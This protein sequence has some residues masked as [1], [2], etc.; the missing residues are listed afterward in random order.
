MFEAILDYTQIAC[1]D[2]MTFKALRSKILRVGNDCI[3]TI[4]NNLSE[5]DI[6]YIPKTEEVIVIKNKKL[7]K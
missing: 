4:N 3:R 6:K 1:S 7:N 2:P 5:Y